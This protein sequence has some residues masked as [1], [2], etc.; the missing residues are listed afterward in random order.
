L[1]PGA[2]PVIPLDTV[3]RRQ[4]PSYAVSATTV[5]AIRNGRPIS[6]HV[7]DLTVLTAGASEPDG[8]SEDVVALFGPDGRFL[9]LYSQEGPLAK[10]VAVFSPA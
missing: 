7:R 1:S 3:A 6:G 9:A 5:D 2:L 10:A 4:F 8:G